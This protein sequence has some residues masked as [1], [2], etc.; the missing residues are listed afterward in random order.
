[1]CV[2]VQKYFVFVQKYFC[3]TT[4]HC[5]FTCVHPVNSEWAPGDAAACLYHYTSH[6]LSQKSRKNGQRNECIL[7]QRN[8]EKA[9][10]MCLGISRL[11]SNHRAC[12]FYSCVWSEW[13]SWCKSCC[14]SCTCTSLLHDLPP[15]AS[16]CLTFPNCCSH[17]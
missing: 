10:R 13:S 9:R 5:I 6:N 16:S 12:G 8:P 1:M 15:C 4:V 2:F 3:C 17:T 7:T 11:A 14:K